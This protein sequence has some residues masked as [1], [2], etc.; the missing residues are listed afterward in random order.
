MTITR[1]Y[2]SV[3]SKEYDEI[4]NAVRKSYPNA[5]VVWIEEV[6]NDELEYHYEL[7]KQEIIKARGACEEKMLFHGTT[8]SSIENILQTGFDP[9]YNKRSACGMGSYFATTAIYSKEYA[10]PSRDEVSFMFMASVLIGKIGVHGYNQVIHTDIH[11]NSVNSITNPSI[12]VTPYRFGAVP[13]RI[14]A[15]Y[16]N[17]K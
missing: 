11:D 6:T 15:F 1:K 10:P 16:R 4:T 9:S 13:R 5:C 17:A 12:Y 8:E 2:L 7:K 14:V 3:S